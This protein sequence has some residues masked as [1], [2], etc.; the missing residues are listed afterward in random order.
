MTTKSYSTDL[1]TR[2]INYLQTGAT[3][4]TAALIFNI[5]KTTVARWS[6]IYKCEE[7]IEAKPR[8]GS[9]GKVDKILLSKFVKDN[10]DKTLVEIGKHF[11]ISSVSVYK[12]LKNLGF[13]YKK[14]LYIQG[15]EC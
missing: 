11:G 15:S 5:S 6:L 10:P 9:C 8:G 1:R 2:V 3:Q 14:K 7:R 4:R 13:S 12:R